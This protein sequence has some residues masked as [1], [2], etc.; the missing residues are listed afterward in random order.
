MPTVRS[1]NL[2]KSDRA[3]RVRR[4]AYAMQYGTLITDLSERYSDTEIRLARAL[5]TRKKRERNGH[6]YRPNR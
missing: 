4:C 6:A 2:S 3:A 5:L 1:E